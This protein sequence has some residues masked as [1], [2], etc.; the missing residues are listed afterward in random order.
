MKLHKAA[1]AAALALAALAHTR[2]AQAQRFT[3]GT[4]VTV[5][6]NW[7]SF[8]TYGFTESQKKAVQ[9]TVINAYT[10]WQ[11]VSGSDLK[12]VFGGYTTRPT[13]YDPDVHDVN[14]YY[15]DNEILVFMSDYHAGR[16][17]SFYSCAVDRGGPGRCGQIVLHNRSS[18]TATP[19]NWT[20]WGSSAANTYDVMSVLMHELGHA[21]DL[22]D[23]YPNP[24]SVMS[25]YNFWNG[26]FGPSRA[27]RDAATAIYGINERNRVRMFRSTDADGASYSLQG[28][29]PDGVRTAMDPSAVR[30]GSD[31]VLFYTSTHKTP[32]FIW[33][34]T[35]GTWNTGMWWCWG[36]SR[37][38]YGIGSD[39]DSDEFMWAF[40]DQAAGSDPVIKVVHSTRDQ[41]KSGT[42]FWR[43]P[44]TSR[45][46]GT[47]GIAQVTDNTWVLAYTRFDRDDLDDTGVIVARVTTN[48]GAS[49]G[50]EIEL[51]AGTYRG[52]SGV[53]VAADAATGDVRIGFGWGASPAGSAFNLIRTIR[54][55]VSGSTLSYVGM[56]YGT[57]ETRTQPALRK[58]SSYYHNKYRDVSANTW[59]I[60]RS[61]TPTAT[62][63]SGSGFVADSQTEATPAIAA[64][65]RYTWT[66]LFQTKRY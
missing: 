11:M 13:G 21:H 38:Q 31:L 50:P 10:R 3:P 33:G 42:G 35:S 9:D 18:A 16:L 41:L 60:S 36:G 5:R 52:A 23:D 30:V 22:P 14:D 17:G 34:N 27:D 1:C 28:N 62:T 4:P 64:D 58:A 63:W 24:T 56:M 29:L 15:K 49:W 65:D 66:Y 37:S 12:F 25:S 53:T 32:C 55:N 48:D 44:P 19:Y 6:I 59:M 47:P 43:S 45:T 20:F 2:D 8:K 7:E 26:R 61:S 46:Y 39:G 54:A 51:G 40:V 57:D